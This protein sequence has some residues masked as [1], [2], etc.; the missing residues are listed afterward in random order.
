MRGS[1]LSFAGVVDDPLRHAPQLKGIRSSSLVLSRPADR[2]A[3]A[4][5]S[6]SSSVTKFAMTR[7][8]IFINVVDR[9]PIG[10]RLG[11]R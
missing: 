9:M 7:K 8:A 6:T 10:P 5:T 11:S 1:R 4:V 3:R 2:H